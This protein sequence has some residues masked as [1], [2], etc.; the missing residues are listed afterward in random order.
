MVGYFSCQIGP[1]T[2][3]QSL[4]CANTVLPAEIELSAWANHKRRLDIL[5]NSIGP[6]SST[7]GRGHQ[8]IHVESN[9]IAR[10]D[11]F[12]HPIEFGA[13]LEEC[14]QDSQVDESDRRSG[15]LDP[16]SGPAI[17]E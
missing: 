9:D 17:R 12:A 1:L 14:K 11:G 2:D 13:D 8:R 5:S 7:R 4:V 15:V 3:L 16:Q 6:K 10:L